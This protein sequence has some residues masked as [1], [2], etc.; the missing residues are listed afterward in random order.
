MNRRSFALALLLLSFFA[1]LGGY[2]LK[3][4]T[5]L[6][7]G[8]RA[9]FC[10]RVVCYDSNHDGFME[11]IFQTAAGPLPTNPL[12]WEIWEHRPMNRYVLVFADTSQNQVWPYP[13]G[14]DRGGMALFDAGDIDRDGRTDLLGETMFRFSDTTRPDSSFYYVVATVESRDSFSYPDT[15]TWYSQIMLTNN[16]QVYDFH[17]VDLDRDGRCDI[18]SYA[19][20]DSYDDGGIRVYENRGNDSNA[21]A[22]QL[23]YRHGGSNFAIGDFDGDSVTEFAIADIASGARVYVFKNT[24]PDQYTEVFTDSILVPNGYDVFPGHD[25]DQDGKPEFFVAPCYVG[26]TFYLYMFE[27]NGQ[28]TYEHT[29]VATKSLPVSYPTSRRSCCGD[30]DGDGVEEII[31][32][33]CNNLY[34]YKATGNNQ[35]QQ[36]WQWSQDH[37]TRIQAILV[38]VADMNNDGYNEIVVGGSDKTSVF[39]MEAIR[40]LNPNTSVSLH[41][42]DT[43]RVRWQTFTPPRCDSISIFLRTDT[44]YRLDTLAHGLLPIATSW[45]W[46][47]PD[48]TSDYCHVVAIAHGPGWQ[49][50]ES[51]TFFRIIPAGVE[52]S[53]CRPRTTQ[54]L[55][56]SP[57]PLTDRAQVQFQLSTEQTVSLRICDVSG[58]TVATLADGVLEPGV[59]RRDW[60]ALPAI[61]NG[62]YFLS[63]TA[64]DLHESRKLILT[65]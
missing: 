6:N 14:L 61:P 64:G 22:W 26:T 58:Q 53:P 17:L 27:P 9:E 35:F 11:L 7:S 23:P 40:V 51:D 45:L 4:V 10:G 57:N 52:E 5:L 56:I 65:R 31:W 43:C 30:I 19:G 18:I 41:P 48:I 62:V 42:G 16:L 21:V 37:G 59:Y 32:S 33:C 38:S 25:V 24:G 55:G 29:L 46:T 8:P 28:N 12:R 47:V 60:Q 50:D 63:F 39:E 15:V 34:V 13:P 49:Y 1:Q 36:V 20:W 3:R 2:Q 54:L 44:S